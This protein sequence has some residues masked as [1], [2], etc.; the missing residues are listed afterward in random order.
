MAPP[1]TDRY[2]LRVANAGSG[3]SSRGAGREARVVREGLWRGCAGGAATIAT[4]AATAAAQKAQVGDAL[5][6]PD[7]LHVAVEGHFVFVVGADAEVRQGRGDVGVWILADVLDDGPLVEG[8]RAVDRRCH[9]AV[10]KDVRL[11]RNPGVGDGDPRPAV[12]PG[13]IDERVCRLLNAPEGHPQLDEGRR[14]PL[15]DEP[16]LEAGVWVDEV[17]VGLPLCNKG[18]VQGLVWLGVVVDGGEDIDHKV[19]RE[20]L[21]RQVR[22][23]LDALPVRGEAHDPRLLDHQLDNAKSRGDR[24]SGLRGGGSGPRATSLQLLRWARVVAAL[25]QGLALQEGGIL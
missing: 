10:D 16:D 1:S 12:R 3:L 9:L 13:E 17:R 8:R 5:V 2:A 22:R 14:S 18:H 7:V 4:G 15:G 23:E 24:G 20:A 21:L 19:E 11:L 6:E 25:H